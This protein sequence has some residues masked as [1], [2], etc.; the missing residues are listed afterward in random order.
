MRR[1]APAVRLLAIAA[2]ISFGGSAGAQDTD[3]DAVVARVRQVFEGF[4][5]RDSAKIASAFLPSAILVTLTDST[6][7]R[8]RVMTVEQIA[9]RFAHATGEPMTE[10]I[11]DPVVHIDG[12]AAQ[13][14]AY[15][16]VH[17]GKVFSRCGTDAVTLLKVY[18]EWKITHFMFVRDVGPC[19][20]SEPLP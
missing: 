13:V 1:P 10:R 16:T 2:I 3:R 17:T 7:A 6:P 4:L 12:P 20:H 5:A 19:T 8:E 15:F 14:W 9:A 18:G 11:F